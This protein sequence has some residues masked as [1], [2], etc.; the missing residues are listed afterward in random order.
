MNPK[1]LLL[2]ILVFPLIGAFIGFVLGIKSE[3]YRDI[4]NIIMTGSVLG[5]V[6][7]LYKYVAVQTIQIWIP[8]IMGVGLY[9][10]LDIFRYIFVWVTTFVWFLTTIYSTQYLTSY[11]NRNRYYLFFMITLSSTIG[12]FISENLLNLFTF[13][14]IMSLASYVLV[15]HDED[16]YSH[17]AGQTYISMAVGGSLILL[18]GLFLLYEYTNTLEISKLQVAVQNIGN[19]KYLISMFI[20]A[21]FG[22]KAG[23][24][25]FH[26]WLPKAH[27]AAPAPASAILSGILVKTGIFGILITAQMI[28]NGDLI[29]STAI[30]ILGF[31]NMFI[32]G[33]L[34]IYQRNIK[35]ILAYSSMSQVGYILVGIGLMG[36]LKGHKAIAIYGTLYHIANHAIF[37]T[38]LFMVAGVIYMVLHELSINKIGGFGRNKKALKLV[39]FIGL[40]AIIGMPGFNGFASK[41]LLHEALSEAHHIYGGIWFTIAEVIFTVSSS[42]TIAYLLKIFFA[43][44]I[45]ESNHDI[46]NEKMKITKKAILPMAILSLAIIYIGIKPN[47]FLNIFDGALK[48]FGE[49]HHIETDFYSFKNIKSSLF[50]ISLGVL[51]YIGVVRRYLRKGSGMNWWYENSALNW[52]SL[53]KRIYI[54]VGKSV[55]YIS[56]VILN[57]IDVGLVKTVEFF[58]NALRELSRVE[59][60]CQKS[61]VG[62]FTDVLAVVAKFDKKNYDENVSESSS[63]GMRS[64]KDQ[65][66]QLIEMA[67]SI[68]YSIFIFG[69]VLV[70]C[71]FV[72][73]N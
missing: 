45:E 2:F 16:D 41:T 25:P 35:R 1:N 54:P 63:Q 28:M 71:L 33:L 26:I 18:M 11:K 59:V 62:K 61:I 19:I 21:G 23:M 38:L 68:T 8:D 70:I 32:G 51:M 57:I 22:V 58:N 13:F 42:F 44:F 36:I 27:P 43:V 72:M 29:V 40:C 9:L 7:L 49:F 31:I 60:D 55:F 53:E 6:T 3:K 47:M 10:K 64:I 48:P 66:G 52:F 50:T 65:V 5:I 56:S 67:S 39:F 24:V 12:I 4:F 30:M 14:E 69:I 46:K 34:A 15:I 20:I 17:E 37:K 73:I